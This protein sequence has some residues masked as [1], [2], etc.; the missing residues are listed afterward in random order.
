MVFPA[1]VAQGAILFA[2][3]A[4]YRAWLRVSAGGSL[5][6]TPAGEGPGRGSWI[7]VALASA[8]GL[9]SPVGRGGAPALPEELAI[10]AAVAG[11]GARIPWPW[12]QLRSI[13]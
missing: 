10:V 12:Q 5:E 11:C 9:A 8:G 6:Y 13:P 2:D 3:V 1:G 7:R 4:I